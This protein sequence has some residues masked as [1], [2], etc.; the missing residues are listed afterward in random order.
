LNCKRANN[1]I[2]PIVPKEM[3]QV[4]RAPLTSPGFD[5]FEQPIRV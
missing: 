4:E 3:E 1:L 5:S 2:I